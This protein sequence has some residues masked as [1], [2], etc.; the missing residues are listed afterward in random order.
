MRIRSV[1]A[2][3]GLGAFLVSCGGGD[4]GGTGP[5]VPGLLEVTLATAPTGPGAIMFTVSGG[6]I[7]A[8]TAAGYTTYQ[9]TTTS[10]SRKVLLTGDITAGTLIE[11]QVPDISK[12][13]N[14][15]GTVLQV[16]ARGTAAVPYQQLGIASYTIDV[17]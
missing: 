10:N 8:V 15:V 7:D 6:P 16:A 9:S 12:V 4:G 5:P 13:N 3:L 14:Y 2:T 17:Q 11:I 1:L